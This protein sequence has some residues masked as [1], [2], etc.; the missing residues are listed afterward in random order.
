MGIYIQVKYDCILYSCVYKVQSNL[1]LNFSMNK[2][3][4]NL[5]KY[6]DFVSKYH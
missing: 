6:P 4:N 5:F 3:Y 2:L 1:I